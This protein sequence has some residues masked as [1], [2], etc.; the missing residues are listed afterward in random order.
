MQRLP[1][2]SAAPSQV[3]EPTA[4][5]AAQFEFSV[6]GSGRTSAIGS[7]S[8]SRNSGRSTCSFRGSGR[9][10]GGASTAAGRYG[11]TTSASTSGRHAP[12]AVPSRS[13]DGLWPSPTFQ[14]AGGGA[15]PQSPHVSGNVTIA[16]AVGDV[17][18]ARLGSLHSSGSRALSGAFSDFSG[19]MTTL[20]R[21]QIFSSPADHSL[22]AEIKLGPLLGKGSFGRVYAGGARA[23][24]HCC[25]ARHHQLLCAM[26]ALAV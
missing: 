10:A 2:A 18:S 1:H 21:G 15:P 19:L 12:A 9:S 5:P 25:A 20:S 13:D 8:S 26:C 17:V 7:I 3:H 16:S 14:A 6:A 24:R 11:I 22:F 4:A 23:P